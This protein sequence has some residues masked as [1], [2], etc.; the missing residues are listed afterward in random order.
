MNFPDTR[1]TLISHLA[2]PEKVSTAL[3]QLCSVYWAP[4][5]AYLLRSGKSHAE[6]QDL[7]Q[8]FLQMVVRQRLLE[9]ADPVAGRLRSWL[10]SALQNFLANA[11]RYESRQKRGAG[12][13]MFALDEADVIPELQG[14][15]S[16]RLSPDEAFDR[17]WIAVLLRRVMDVLAEQYRDAGK[18][19]D[20]ERLLPW[21]LDTGA[22]PQKQAATE[23]GMSLPNFRV[24]LHRL[25][26]RY[27]EILR[28]EVIVT[29]EREEDYDEEIDYLFRIAGRQS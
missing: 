15:A 26:G 23:A 4:I 13:V 16:Q 17:A 2:D 1:W 11:R 14:I 27:R 12:A 22:V 19:A 28:Q 10:L 18:A 8:D 29:L 7:T 9:R 3:D 6:A 24:Q 20:Y 21:L 25:R 5:Y